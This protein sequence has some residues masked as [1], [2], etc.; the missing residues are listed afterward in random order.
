M[1]LAIFV[2]LAS[3]IGN[4]G[5]IFAITGILL[6]VIAASVWGIRYLSYAEDASRSYSKDSAVKPRSKPFVYSIILGVTLM[7]LSALLPSQKTMYLMAG[8][9]AGQ[10]VVQS[11]T[12]DKVL[13]VLNS[14]LDEYLSE[15]EKEKK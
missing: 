6:V 7:L 14:K 10:R 4:V 8:A 3:V 5:V 12:A 9:Y 1:E 2:Y 15:T 13:K 11:Y